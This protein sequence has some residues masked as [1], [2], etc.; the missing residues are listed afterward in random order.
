MLPSVWRESP[1]ALVARMPSSSARGAGRSRCATHALLKGVLVAEEVVGLELLVDGVDDFLLRLGEPA[2]RVV[3]LERDRQPFSA[4]GP[5]RL[6]QFKHRLMLLADLREDRPAGAAVAVDRV[7]DGEIL[8][9]E[10]R[11]RG[12]ELRRGRKRGA[13]PG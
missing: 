4:L 11:R 1:V 6:L 3:E 13:V 5:Q 8:L 10:V 9:A 2:Q 12:T 7:G